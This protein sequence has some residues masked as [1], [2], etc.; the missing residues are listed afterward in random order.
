MIIKYQVELFMKLVDNKKYNFKVNIK[1]T[2]YKISPI[3]N[4]TKNKYT[5]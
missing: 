4:R 1:Q 3:L 5:Y 2:L